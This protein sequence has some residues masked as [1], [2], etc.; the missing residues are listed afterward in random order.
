MATFTKQHYPPTKV[1]AL[2]SSFCDEE[3][4]S[5]RLGNLPKVTQLWAWICFIPDP[6]AL[7]AC[8]STCG[9]AGG[10]LACAQKDAGLQKGSRRSVAAL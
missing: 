2:R 8:R 1:G 6:G 7:A 9:G 5:E 10:G 4:G 3:T